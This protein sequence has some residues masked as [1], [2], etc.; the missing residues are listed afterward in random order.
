MKKLRTLLVDDEPLM[1][2]ELQALL[3]VYPDIEIVGSCHDSKEALEKITEL[4]PDLV[5]LDIKMP[6]KSGIQIAKML[7]HLPSAP[8]L[9]FATAYQN[10][11]MDA[12]GVNAIDYILKP[13]DEN[14]IDRAV[15]KARRYSASLTAA[16]SSSSQAPHLPRKISAE[17]DD[18]LEI[19]DQ[20]DIQVIYTQNRSVL[21]QTRDGRTLTGR[22]SLQEYEELLDPDIFVR[23]HRGYIIN[24]ECIQRLDT[25]FNR[26][27]MVT[28]S[29]TKPQEV[30]VSRIYVKKLKQFIQF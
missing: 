16:A 17:A 20:R 27:Y 11:A 9:V 3:E 7:E 13:F 10:F 24:V 18:R 2:Q 25:W 30:P 12:F 14:D 4:Q 8:M 21:I 29:G 1:C 6:G 28:L 23:C 26:G 5:F 19:I 22:M 15:R